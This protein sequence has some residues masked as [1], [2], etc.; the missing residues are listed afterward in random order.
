[1]SA[2]PE[3]QRRATLQD[4]REYNFDGL[5]GPTH[6]YAGLSRGNLA[7]ER[8]AGKVAN[9]KAA[10]L[11][12]LAKMRLLADLGVGQAVLP[13][14]PRP[15]VDALRR[16]GFHGSDKDVLASASKGDGHL[17]RL[18]SSASSMWTANA[19]TVAPSSDTTDGRVHLTVANLSAMFHR[20]LEASE[21]FAVLRAVFA[22][23]AHFAVHAP[24]LPG[25]HFADEGAANHLRLSTQNGTV[26]LFGWGRSG[27]E[28]SRDVPVFPRRQTREASSAVARLN[29]LSESL[30]LPWQQDPPG[31][32]AGAFHSDVLAVANEDF[33]MMHEHAFVH[34]RDLLS[35]LKGRLGADFR[36]V[37]AHESELPAKD[38]VGAYP[39]NSQIVTLPSGDMAIV[40]PAEAAASIAARGF[41][42]R[43]VS[44]DNRVRAV[45]YVDVNASMNNGGGPACL[46]LR[47]CVTD[48][49]RRAVRARVFFD[50]ALH[51]DLVRWIEHGYRDRMDFSDLA[52]PEV[53]VETRTALDELTKILRLG[54]IYD[55]QK[56]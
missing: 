3:N 2:G 13:P 12:G 34:H 24:L 47:I 39:F 14:A 48:E 25:S 49:E 16:L 15:N 17:L 33:L 43:V 4:V 38:A 1:M 45:H 10:A 52:D 11:Q 31:I 7:S 37:V 9:P 19:A 42:D 26:H 46:R 51:G 40:A 50:D 20:S 36:A 18:V 23:E 56:P 35:E 6:N 41:L 44:E 8:H 55:F 32:D 53:L 5:V 27:F 30:V 28:G 29:A 21:T 22:D 54:S